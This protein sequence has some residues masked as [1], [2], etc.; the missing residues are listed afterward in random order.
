MT[1]LRSS[2]EKIR[3]YILT[4]VGKHPSDI[5]SIAAKKFEISRQAVNKHLQRLVDENC[6]A[7]EGKTRSRIYKLRAMVQWNGDFRITKT[8]A[9]DVVWREELQPKMGVMPDNVIDIWHYGF[10]E[11][12]NNVIDLNFGAIL[13]I[14]MMK[15]YSFLVL[16]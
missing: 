12:F 8:L 2:S 11:M 14:S 5:A 13:I 16:K 4:N 15:L 1:K 6:L 9:E 3:K 7:V 10:T